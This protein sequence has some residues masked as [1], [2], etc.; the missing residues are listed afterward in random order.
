MEDNKKMNYLEMVY[1]YM[2][3]GYDEETACLIADGE[4]NLGLYDNEV[5]KDQKGAAYVIEIVVS[6][7]GYKMQMQNFIIILL[8][9][10]TCMQSL[11][12]G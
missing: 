1:Y 10:L 6:V 9:V 3:Q 2:D 11:M 4:F 12:S 5:W 8:N 7:R